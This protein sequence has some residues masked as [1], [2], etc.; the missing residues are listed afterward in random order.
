MI[1][2]FYCMMSDWSLFPFTIRALHWFC[3]FRYKGG[4]GALLL[5]EMPSFQSPPLWDTSSI[6]PLSIVYSGPSSHSRY[7]WVVGPCFSCHSLLKLQISTTN[8]FFSER[9]GKKLREGGEN[10]K[11]EPVALGVRWALLPAAQGTAFAP[12]EQLEECVLSLQGC[13]CVV[14]VQILPPSRSCTAA[15]LISEL[16]RAAALGQREPLRAQDTASVVTT[17]PWCWSAA[18]QQSSETWRESSPPPCVCCHPVPLPPGDLECAG[19]LDLT[20]MFSILK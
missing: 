10:V 7:M 5:S 2:W 11:R 17:A 15:L 20:N 19:P 3:K 12:P 16:A 9:M 8:A 18:G 4:E 6:T 1:L 13:F 14:V